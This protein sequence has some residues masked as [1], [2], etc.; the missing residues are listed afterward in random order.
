MS[1]KTV[2]SSGKNVSVGVLHEMESTLKVTEVSMCRNK[3]VFIPTHSSG[4][5]GSPLLHRCVLH[6]LLG[7]H[8]NEVLGQQCGW[9]GLSPRLCFV[10]PNRWVIWG[11]QIFLFGFGFL[12]NST[13]VLRINKLLVSYVTACVSRRTPSCFSHTSH[14]CSR[15][16]PA[17]HTPCLDCSPHCPRLLPSWLARP[18]GFS[19]NVTSWRD[20]PWPQV[21]LY[22]TA[23]LPQLFPL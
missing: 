4:S 12:T 6:A 11:K 3:Y 15:I 20:T 17:C 13:L 23:P 9:F 10:S 14:F 8:R 2:L 18:S 19:S 16:W 7:R 1:S 22:D 5:F 21:N